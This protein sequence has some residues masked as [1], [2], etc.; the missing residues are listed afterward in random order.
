MKELIEQITERIKELQKQPCD[1]NIGKISELTL[2]N[3]KLKALN[4]QDVSNCCPECNSTEWQQYSK[5]D[6]KCMNCG[7]I[8]GC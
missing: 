2:I 7:R 8:Y 3:I 1:I 4:V 5:T 6:N